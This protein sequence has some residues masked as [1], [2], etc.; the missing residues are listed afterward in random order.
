MT[1]QPPIEKLQPLLDE[2]NQKHAD[3]QIITT[4][5]KNVHFLNAY[6]ENKKGELYSRVYHK[7]TSQP[8]VLPYVIDHPRLFYRKWMQWALTRAVRY[9]TAI[10]D[11]NQER[12]SIELT[13]LAN[14]Y[15]FDFIKMGITKFF[16]KSS[17]SNFLNRFNDSA[18]K[19]L[20]KQ[21]FTSLEIEKQHR[22][23]Q[24]IWKSN[25]QIIH[26]HYLYDWG[27]R[28]QF[29]TRFKTL[30]SDL[31]KNDSNLNKIDL[32]L[33]LSCIHCYTLNTL[34]T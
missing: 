9:C 34:L 11:F 1:W 5:G 3:I 10:E 12:L 33:K 30:W 13:L 19:S 4:I 26:L 15:S 18:Y 22:K 23:Q 27:P 6:I 32:K 8:F 20:R 28:C 25:N 21:L 14:G 24:Q 31:I 7:P 17:M 16:T 29:N 2:L